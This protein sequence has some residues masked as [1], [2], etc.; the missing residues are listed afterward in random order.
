MFNALFPF[1]ALS[2][3]FANPAAH[4]HPG[5]CNRVIAA[6]ATG[7]YNGRHLY[8]SPLKANYFKVG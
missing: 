7:K 5:F 8:E 1:L 2:A 3:P 6:E 4:V